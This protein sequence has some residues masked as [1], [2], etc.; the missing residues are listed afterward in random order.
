M[1]FNQWIY[2][3]LD[4][5]VKFLHTWLEAKSTKYAL[6]IS[7]TNNTIQKGKEPEDQ[8]PVQAIGF[9][10]PEYEYIEE[11]DDDDG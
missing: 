11:D 3:I 10:V 2:V 8:G 6:I 7:E 5:F 4:S 9:S 1:V